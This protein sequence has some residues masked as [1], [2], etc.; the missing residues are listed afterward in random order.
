MSGSRSIASVSRSIAPLPTVNLCSKR[1]GAS[2]VAFD[3]GVSGLVE[4]VKNRSGLAW[5][6][7]QR[8]AEGTADNSADSLYFRHFINSVVIRLSH[9]VEFAVSEWNLRL[10]RITYRKPV[11]R[12]MS[13]RGLAPRVA[14]RWHR[15]DS[16]ERGVGVRVS[17]D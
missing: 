6:L 12:I 2:V 10:A 14:R 16:S 5:K 17:V 4:D 13:V 3:R 7:G 8:T 11:N 15:I 1:F 9:V